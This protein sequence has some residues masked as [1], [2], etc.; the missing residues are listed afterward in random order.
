MDRGKRLK[1]HAEY[2]RLKSNIKPIRPQPEAKFPTRSKPDR[3]FRRAASE[4]F[5]AAGVDAIPR[6]TGAGE[7]TIDELLR[8]KDEASAKRKVKYFSADVPF[9]MLVFGLLCFGLVMMYSASYAWSINNFGTPYKYINRQLLAAALGIIAMVFLTYIDYNKLKKLIIPFYLSSIVLLIMVLVMGS[10]SGGAKRWL[11]VGGQTFQPSEFAKLAVILMLAWVYSSAGNRIKRFSWGILPLL[12]TLATILPFLL[13]QKHLSA[14]VLV[15]LTAASMAFI[16]GA[17]I[18]WIGGL[19]AFGAGIIYVAVT[20]IDEFAYVLARLSVWKNPF[21]DPSNLG[22]QTIQSL[23]AIASGGIFGLGLGQS[24]QKQLYLPESHN[25][26]VFSIVCEE[27][28]LVGAVLLICLFTVL[29]VRGYW[30]AARAADKFGGLLVCGIMTLLALQTFMNIAVV[31]NTMPVT[32][33]SLP[34]FSYG[35][36]SL[37]LQLAEMGL[38]LSVSRQM[39]TGKE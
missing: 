25:D 35:G 4:A 22:Y 19:G 2:D 6:K 18:L 1:A 30:I 3:A 32:G 39:R 34:F 24:R 23:Y 21:V 8:S 33:V 28:G 14:T 37:M 10:E 38:V 7:S 13:L 20:K 29:I 15:T 9:F 5:A 17:N 26:Y 12:G 36:T 27:L 11:V 31:T 16:A